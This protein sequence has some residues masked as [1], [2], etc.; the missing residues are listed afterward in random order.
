VPQVIRLTPEVLHEQNRTLKTQQ[1]PTIATLPAASLP[2]SAQYHA[3]ADGGRQQHGFGN[4]IGATRQPQAESPP[5]GILQQWAPGSWPTQ[6]PAS[7]AP[8]ARVRI[9]GLQTAQEMN[10]QFGRVSNFDE[11]KSRWKVKLD[12]GS[13]KMFRENNL[14][15]VEM[16]VPP[17]APP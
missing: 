8:G 13:S 15:V 5:A 1:A 12:S 16:P 11:G 3:M 2:M 4:G 17:R 14:E 9:H 6:Q 10:G 7:L